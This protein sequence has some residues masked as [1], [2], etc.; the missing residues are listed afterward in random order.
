MGWKRKLKELEIDVSSFSDIAFLLIIFFILTTSLDRPL[1]RVIDVPSA[2]KPDAK[3]TVNRTPSVNVLPDRIL[4]GEGEEAGKEVTLSELRAA[5]LKR[6]LD[7]ANDKDRMVV[8]EVG[9]DV[10]YERYFQ[11][12]TMVAEAGGIVAMLTD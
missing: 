12:V 10:A 2:S 5:L 6:R 4:L 1:G 9:E 7:A 3:T 11:I 8:V